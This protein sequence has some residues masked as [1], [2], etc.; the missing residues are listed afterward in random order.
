MLTDVIDIC[1]RKL[2]GKE[3]TKT[4]TTND[5]LKAIKTAL[6][7]NNITSDIILKNDNG[8]QFTSVKFEHFCKLNN[9]YH[10]L[11]P[12]NSPN[13]NAHIESFHFLLSKKCLAW[14]DI[15]NFTHGYMIIHEYIKFYNEERIHVSLN[16]MSPNELIIIRMKLLKIRGAIRF[17][18][19]NILQLERCSELYI[20][21]DT[22]TSK[23]QYDILCVEVV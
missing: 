18:L 8:P 19:Q 13:Y 6:L 16:C 5:A 12:T 20:Q 1:S 17:L 22:L 11:I 21:I 23:E 15:E 7:E 4:A 10:E 2:V 3:I 9:M 14:Y